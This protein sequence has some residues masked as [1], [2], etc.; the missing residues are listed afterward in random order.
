MMHAF[1]TK[2][3]IV[4]IGEEKPL[5]CPVCLFVLR[6]REDMKSVIKETACSECVT[7]FKYAHSGRWNKGWRPSVDEARKKMHI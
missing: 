1:D 5:S 6:D 7:N 3:K 4:S 2:M